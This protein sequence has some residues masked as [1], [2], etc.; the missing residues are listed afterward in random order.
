[1]SKTISFRCAAAGVI[2]GVVTVSVVALA[3]CAKP[4][5]TNRSV[6]SKE[7]VDAR[8][9]WERGTKVVIEIWA[10]EDAGYAQALAAK[11][12]CPVEDLAHQTPADAKRVAAAH[13]AVAA[14]FDEQGHA[15]Y[16]AV[17]ADPRLVGPQLRKYYKDL[18]VTLP[19]GTVGTVE[20]VSLSGRTISIT[21]LNALREAVLNGRDPRQDPALLKI[22]SDYL[23]GRKGVADAVDAYLSQPAARP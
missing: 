23:A 18:K 12:D 16:V 4:A 10:A 6:A 15:K 5:P 22:R 19:D 1:M 11:L 17:N 14:Q 7:A 3:S 13:E 2:A 8:D 20:S 9:G 21:Y